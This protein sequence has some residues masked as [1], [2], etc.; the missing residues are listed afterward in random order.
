M[1]ADDMRARN[2]IASQIWLGISDDSHFGSQL[3]YVE[4]FIN[5]QHQG[6]YCLGPKINDELISLLNNDALLYKAIGWNGPGC[7]VKSS[8]N[9]STIDIWDGWVQKYPPPAQRINWGPLAD[10]RNLV[11]DGSDQEFHSR[12]DMLIDINKFIDYY[13][14]L[15]L[16]CA[17]DN[18][19]K[20]IYLT[21]A[22]LAKPLCV[23]PWDYDNSF[24]FSKII[25]NNP[26]YQRLL[27]LDPVNFRQRLKDR[28]F[29]LRNNSFSLDN[30]E[31]IIRKNFDEINKS[32][33]INIENN[34]WGSSIYTDCEN[35][36]SWISARSKTLDEYYSDL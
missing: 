11:V 2:K 4:L 34:K 32:N 5:N 28:W 19:N 3:N 26:L 21:R 29:Y 36:I 13:L 30:L 6:L 22:S 17:P 27:L 23:I 33:I 8:S 7:F 16:I 12:I 9:I 1:F 25:S 10:L 24:S 15:N 20:N 35:I 14:F 31:S 18:L